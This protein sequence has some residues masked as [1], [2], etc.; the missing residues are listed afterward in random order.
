MKFKYLLHC[1]VFF[2]L[3]TASCDKIATD[4]SANTVSRIV[5][6]WKCDE[7]SSIFKSALDFYTVYI[8]INP[9]DSTK[10]L[11]ENFYQ[12]GGDV[13]VGASI[14]G[15]NLSIPQQTVSA[16]FKIQGQG[17]INSKYDEISLTYT[18]ES[19]SS[20]TDEVSAVYTKTNN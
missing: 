18:V 3:L 1:A 9:S 19:E 5:G 17:T 2:A 4:D 20:E 10:V 15:L 12:L 8:K 16:G 7:H 6:Q 13:Q 11:I 14:S